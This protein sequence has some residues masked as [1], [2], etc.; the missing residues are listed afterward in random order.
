MSWRTRRDSPYQGL[1][2]E[3]AEWLE[4]FD[5]YWDTKHAG[6]CRTDAMDHLHG[7][8]TH[9]AAPPPTESH[10]SLSYPQTPGTPTDHE[11]ARL[12]CELSENPPLIRRYKAD[13]GVHVFLRDH[14]PRLLRFK[15][16]IEAKKSSRMILEFI[17][18]A[19]PVLESRLTR[20][21]HYPE[22]HP[23]LGTPEED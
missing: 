2:D 1:T 14:P 16:L 18:L 7:D 20:E 5:R 6:R 23:D 10:P 19:T 8:S 9:T 3:Q 11:I 22:G 17:T 21:D 4:R 12:S 15:T 13:F